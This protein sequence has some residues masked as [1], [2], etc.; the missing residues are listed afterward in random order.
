MGGGAKIN[1]RGN[2]SLTGNNRAN[3]LLLTVFQSATPTFHMVLP[4]VVDMTWVTL[5]ETLTRTI[6]NQCPFL[7]VLPQPHFYGSRAA[8]GVVMVTTKKAKAA[9][10][11]FGVSVNSSVT[12]DRAA[13]VPKLRRSMVL[14]ML[15]QEPE[16]LMVSSQQ[17]L[18]AKPTGLLTMEQ[19]KAGVL[20]TMQALKYSTGT[21]SIH[22]IQQ[23]IWLKDLGFIL[24]TT[25]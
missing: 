22:G 1:V 15:I 20:N 7:K 5:Q 11:T 19:T 21:L 17:L 16:H 2:T 12:I 10:K 24:K 23:T 25:I 14:V 13:Y 4:V 8:N 6:S 9:Q 18:E 3:C